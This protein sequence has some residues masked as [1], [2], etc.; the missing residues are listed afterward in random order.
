MGWGADGQ[1]GLGESSSSDRCVPTLIER[2]SFKARG[3]E[4]GKV[5][6]ISSSTDFTLALLDNKQI[7]IWGNSEYGQCMLNKKIDRVTSSLR[8][9]WFA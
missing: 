4:V 6:D 7:W 8:K 1:L 5:L 3:K 2:L 9:K